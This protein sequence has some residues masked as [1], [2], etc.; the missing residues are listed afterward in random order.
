MG[1]LIPSLI[2]TGFMFPV[3]NMPLPLQIISNIVPSKWFYII[4]KSIMIKGLGIKAIFKEIG[5]L[6]FMNLVILAI[7]LRK[8]KIR[9]E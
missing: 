1:M 2:F 3:E 5:I 9:L 4:V 6:L 8:F 7:S